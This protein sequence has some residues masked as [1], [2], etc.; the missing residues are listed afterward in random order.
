MKNF[1]YLTIFIAGMISLS[2]YGARLAPISNFIPEANISLSQI[3]QSLPNTTVKFITL[4]PQPKKGQ[5]YYLYVATVNSPVLYSIFIDSSANCHGAKICIL[6][7][8]TAERETNPQI[9]YDMN[10]QEITK[11]VCLSNH[12]KAYFTPAHAMADYW[13]ARIEWRDGSTFYSL[14]W[15]GN[16]SKSELLKMANSLVTIN[17]TS[18][19]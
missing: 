3:A 9:Y 1:K 7:Q 19:S 5:N 17:N 18:G 4:A 8:L 6:G 15:Q 12:Q 10:N 13:P 16:M 2:A 11:T 14:S